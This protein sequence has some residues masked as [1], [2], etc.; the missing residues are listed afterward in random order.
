MQDAKKFLQFAGS[1]VGAVCA[2]TVLSHADAGKQR[3][4]S[5]HQPDHDAERDLLGAS[6][7]LVST[8]S[9]AHT[10]NQAVAFQ[11]DEN[12]LEELHWNGTPR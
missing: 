9:P 10:A 1:E 3:Q 7:K 2:P 6:G 11:F 5:F 12:G 8:V 4:R